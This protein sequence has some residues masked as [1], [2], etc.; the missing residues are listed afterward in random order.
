MKVGAEF[1]FGL[2][3]QL[4]ELCSGPRLKLYHRQ[5]VDSAIEKLPD[6]TGK[7]EWPACLAI[8]DTELCSIVELSMMV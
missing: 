7:A 3:W 6:G 2:G 1:S 5:L 4:W 8:Q